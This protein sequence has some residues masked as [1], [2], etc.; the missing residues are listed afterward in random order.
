VD[1][2]TFMTKALTVK[3]AAEF[4]SPSVSYDFKLG[5]VIETEVYKED[6]DA[7][8]RVEH[9]HRGIL[10]AGGSQ[11]ERTATNLTIIYEA[12]KLDWNYLIIDTK[13]QYRR[14]I[15]M[16]PETRVYPGKSICVNPLDPEDSSVSEYIPLLLS[17]FQVLWNLTD[18]QNIALSEAL[19]SVYEQGGE[20]PP[21][22][23]DLR[24]ALISQSSSKLRTSQERGEI[25][26]LIRRVTGLVLSEESPTINGPSTMPFR[27]LTTNPT[28]IEISPK[29]Q[30]FSGFLKGL[31]VV[32]ALATSKGRYSILL[33]DAEEVFRN[34]RFGW[35]TQQVY[36]QESLTHWVDRLKNMR[37]GL[38]L[39]TSLPRLIYDPVRPL[40]ETQVFHR[41]VSGEDMKIAGDLMGLE[42]H[43]PG[44]HSEKR[45]RLYQRT[46][47]RYLKK[48]EALLHQP[49]LPA[50]F[51]VTLHYSVGVHS[52]IPSDREIRERMEEL[53]PL[54]DTSVEDLPFT[55]L[56][57]D[58]GSEV[59]DAVKILELLREY[60]Q[61]SLM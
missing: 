14:L 5:R 59:E 23:E 61:L 18:R 10:V 34:I 55:M 9:L 22:L 31:V 49:D 40:L 35:R 4:V 2:A 43:A 33:D 29:D 44:I 50:G 16:N 1:L 48:G 53:Y 21:T 26:G 51:P 58:L 60:P 15:H 20:E 30:L 8:L 28:V 39:S 24:N 46:Y 38:H 3:P 57:R 11:E 56:E 12:S 27:E 36:F 7:G 25:E 47:L 13:K 32:K 54:R 37:V 52:R 42:E 17:L 41:L 6:V 45:E 19:R